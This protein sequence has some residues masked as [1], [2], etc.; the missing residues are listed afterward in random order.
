M[1]RGSQF[2]VRNTSHTTSHDD[3]GNGVDDPTLLESIPKSASITCGERQTF[4]G[5]DTTIH[6]FLLFEAAQVSKYVK[7]PVYFLATPCVD[8]NVGRCLVSS[9]ESA[10]NGFHILESPKVCRRTTMWP[11]L[12]MITSTV[13]GRLGYGR[14]SKST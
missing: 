2:H 14:S 7:T 1:K 6:G 8:A 3:D 10:S 12:D 11:H 5:P 13:Q 4:I 9:P